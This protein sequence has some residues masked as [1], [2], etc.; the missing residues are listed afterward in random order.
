MCVFRSRVESTNSPINGAGA[1]GYP[2][3]KNNWMP[4]LH[5]TYKSVSDD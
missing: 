3:R 5:F 4:T 2:Y 1:S